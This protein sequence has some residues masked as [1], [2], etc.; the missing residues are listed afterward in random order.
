MLWNHDCFVYRH[1]L[2]SM[3]SVPLW[4]TSSSGLA[5]PSSR[6]REHVTHSNSSF[7]PH[8]FCVHLGWVVSILHWHDDDDDVSCST[9]ARHP[10]QGLHCSVS[11]TT[12]SPDSRL[13]IR[14]AQAQREQRTTS[15]CFDS[16]GFQYHCL[17]FFYRV[18][19]FEFLR[20][21]IA[22]H[23]STV[24]D[25]FDK[26]STPRYFAT[27]SQFI[28]TA[29]RKMAAGQNAFDMQ[30]KLLMIGDSGTWIALP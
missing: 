20:R 8:C 21:A 24:N 13:S 28:S 23:Y 29:S 14:I 5:F 27:F 26:S 7:Y 25:C 19:L 2:L 1:S 11:P 22:W 4:K 17:A 30:I 10:R 15:N 18:A 16:V 9:T 3:N 6:S 12:F